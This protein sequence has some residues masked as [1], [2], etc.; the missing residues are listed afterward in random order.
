MA[1]VSVEE[2]SNLRMRS[3]KNIGNRCARRLLL[4]W[5][6]AGDS[7]IMFMNRTHFAWFPDVSCPF[8]PDKLNV[9]QV[10]SWISFGPLACQSFE[11][12]WS[13]FAFGNQTWLAGPPPIFHGTW[14]SGWRQVNHAIDLL[15]SVVVAGHKQARATRLPSPWFIMIYIYIYTYIYTQTHTQIYIY[16]YFIDIERGFGDLALGGSVG[17][18]LCRSVGTPLIFVG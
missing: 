5:L 7:F 18:S 14:D 10:A 15:S 1:R 8:F 16:I 4:L 11:H 12:V 9:D 17:P 6:V 13:V 2:P 3:M